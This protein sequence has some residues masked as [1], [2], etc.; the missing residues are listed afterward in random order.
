MPLSETL[1]YSDSVSTSPAI[2]DR[3]KKSI[4]HTDGGNLFLGTFGSSPPNFA[5]RSSKSLNSYY[6]CPTAPRTFG[7]IISM[8]SDSSSMSKGYILFQLKDSL[9]S[10][11][12]HDC[13]NQQRDLL[14]LHC[15]TG[16]RNNMQALQSLYDK[17]VE[18]YPCVSSAPR[19]VH[20][21]G[22]CLQW[23]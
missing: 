3:F 23:V 20:P 11:A 14:L 7:Q 17:R 1:L 6:F 16:R 21:P 13:K 2:Q 10:Q 15:V 4:S 18:L 9:N 5:R 12:P 22:P 8:S 19:A